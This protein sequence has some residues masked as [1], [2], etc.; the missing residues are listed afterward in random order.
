MGERAA[1]AQVTRV[2]P[3]AARLA[4][5][6]EAIAQAHRMAVL[7]AKTFVKTINF[8]RKRQRVAADAHQ[9]S[10]PPSAAKWRRL[11]SSAVAGSFRAGRTAVG[12]DTW[13]VRHV[14]ALRMHG[15][16]HWFLVRWEGDHEDSWRPYAM[17]N[18]TSQA[19][20]HSTHSARST[21]ALRRVHRF[22]RALSTQCTKHSEHLM[23]TCT[24]CTGPGQHSALS[25]LTFCKH[26]C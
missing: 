25:A 24:Q 16:A 15:R 19:A 5:R 1:R 17:L 14:I 3:V 13:A 12:R 9:G 11:V 18:A 2:A 22:L 20:A 21:L 8:E 7:T 4:A 23:C 6:Q 10:A 26:C